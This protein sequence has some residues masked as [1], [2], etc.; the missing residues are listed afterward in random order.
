ME[1]HGNRCSEP[2]M[3]NNSLIYKGLLLG[4]RRCA[5]VWQWI[6]I[7]CLKFV[8]LSNCGKMYRLFLC[9]FLKL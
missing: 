9:L 8:G 2:F 7:L 6:S 5:S 1:V 3:E 4:R